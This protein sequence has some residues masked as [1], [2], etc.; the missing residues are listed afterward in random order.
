MNFLPLLKSAKIIPVLELERLEDAGPLARALF[1]GG[2]K[3]VEL[4][5]RTSAA[6]AGIGAMRKAA[7]GLAVGMGSIRTAED[8]ARSIDAGAEFLVSPGA[9]PALLAAMAKSGAN[10][11]PGIASVSEAMTAAEAGFT[12]MK[13]F[14]AEAV[15]GVPFLKSIAG[16]L[17]SIRFCPTG[18]ISADR[19]PA[20]LQL[21]NV[22]CIGGSWIATREHIAN[23]DWS[24]IEANARFAASL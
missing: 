3:V 24:A 12:A 11:L 20:Y 17:P 9:S 19:A 13:F 1:A 14:P 16:P 22:L 8:V 7:P 23:R 10:A 15:G 2:L 5:L 4:T 6:I 18:G 21:P